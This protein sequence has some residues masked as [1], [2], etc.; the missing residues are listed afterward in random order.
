MDK[1]NLLKKILANGIVEISLDKPLLMT[2]GIW[3]PVRFCSER[4]SYKNVKLRGDVVAEMAA[5]VKTFVDG[6]GVILAAATREAEPLVAVLASKLRLKN[7]CLQGHCVGDDKVY[8]FDKDV[9]K[10]SQ[11]IVIDCAIKTNISKLPDV[12]SI[13][14]YGGQI[15]A[16]C[17]LFN[18]ELAASLNFSSIPFCSILTFS[19]L[20]EEVTAEQ[21][22]VLIHWHNN[23][24]CWHG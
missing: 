8:S 13:E 9:V 5:L 6:R 24:S 12:A 16:I 1:K 3:A 11:V 4:I 20:L 18:Y 10:N 22:Q 21:R 19:D 15:K 14:S 2:E 7:I 17:A 23:P